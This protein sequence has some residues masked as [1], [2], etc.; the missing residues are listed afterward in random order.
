MP[1]YLI[2]CISQLILAHRYAIHW[3]GN[4][5]T[6]MCD[7]YTTAF[8]PVSHD[9]AAGVMVENDSVITSGDTVKLR[10][11]P[12]AILPT[13]PSNSYTI[14]I[15]LREYDQESGRWIYTEL[16]N[17]MPNLGLIEIAV[18]ERT[19]KSDNDTATPAVFQIGVSESSSETQLHKRGI[20][21]KIIKGIVKAVKFVTKVVVLAVS[22]V[23]EPAR[24]LACEA[25]GLF[26]SR[27]T[28]QQILSRLPPCPCTVAEIR[29]L[30]SGF[31]E[32]N[33]GVS[34]IFHPGSDVC[35]RQR[36]P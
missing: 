22:T 10:W 9:K 28:S 21:Y 18:P 36:N 8:Y 14:N 23:I 4:M 25:W 32:E 34:K 11:T 15:M 17:N 35:F 33:S 27:A 20:F 5:I 1:N 6:S 26:Q 29:A 16:A 31:E 13:E 7:I 19:P 2:I 12:E 30:G 24:R 3:A